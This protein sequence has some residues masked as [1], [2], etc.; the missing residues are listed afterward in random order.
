M[1]MFLFCC[2]LLLKMMPASTIIFYLLLSITIMQG[3]PDMPCKA[4]AVVSISNSNNLYSPWK[5]TFFYNL[6]ASDIFC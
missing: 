4:P 2:T 1:Q 6:N 3:P 5:I